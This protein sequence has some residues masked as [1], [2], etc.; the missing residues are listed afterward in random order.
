MFECLIMGDSIAVGIHQ[1]SHNCDKMARIGI[2]SEHWYKIYSVNHINSK[3]V[4]ISLGSNDNQNGIITEEK[5]K[6][7]RSKI[8]SQNVI[9]IIPNIKPIIQSIIIEIARKN[10]DKTIR[11]PNISSDGVHPTITGYKKLAEETR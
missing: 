9:W 3:T 10:G 5:L 11:I 4:V 2:S 7:I 1:F 6:L 8:N